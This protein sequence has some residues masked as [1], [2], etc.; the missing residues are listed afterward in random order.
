MACLQYTGRIRHRGVPLLPSLLLQSLLLSFL[1]LWSA[2]PGTWQD[3][4]FLPLCVL[5]AWLI[6]AASLESAQLR[7]RVWLAQY[8]LPSSPWQH[9][10][11]GGLL[12]LLWHV[13]LAVILTV[14]LLSRLP[15]LTYASLLLL[16]GSLPLFWLMRCGLASLLGRHVQLHYVP[17]LTRRLLR[18]FCVLL[19]TLAYLLIGV[20]QP[21]P[22]LQGM[23]WSV[24]VHMPDVHGS[25]S[26]FGV[27]Q[28][29]H[30]LVDLSLQW[31]MQNSLGGFTR[32]GLTG[33]LGWLLL[34]LSGAAFIWAWVDMLTGVNRITEQMA[35]QWKRAE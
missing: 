11:R 34:L 5:V 24:A 32:S 20:Y 33:L 27:L 31:G 12:M 2:L 30:G 15:L 18:P 19:L 35:E 25:A 4:L 29:F 3:R 1:L 22:W 10:L 7:R 28:R 9:R 14:L 21:Q 13:P 23:N 16:A 17:A 6:L 8:L 26:L